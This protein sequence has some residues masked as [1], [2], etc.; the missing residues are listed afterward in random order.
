MNETLRFEI[1]KQEKRDAVKHR[2]KREKKWKPLIYGSRILLAL[3]AMS[4]GLSLLMDDL[5]YAIRA[6]L[7][8]TFSLLLVIGVILRTFV[9]AFASR[10]IMDRLEEQIW[11]RDGVLNQLVFFS[12]SGGWANRIPGERAS[13]NTIFLNSVK[14]ALY[15]PDSGRIELCGVS[16]LTLYKDYGKKIIDS[17][18]QLSEKYYH[19]FYDY[20]SPSL[21]D[22]L[23][24]Y[25][26]KFEKGPIEYSAFD[27]RP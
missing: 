14:H 7:G 8:V 10:W 1:T 11:V 5:S 22:Y 20:T 12:V 23:L 2:I 6:S 19:V 13:L 16:R 26:I 24:A 25:G 4:L 9:T 17:E 18:H 21:Y 27:R 3:S 15:D